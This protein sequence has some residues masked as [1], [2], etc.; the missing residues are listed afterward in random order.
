[1][2]CVASWRVW[3]LFL[4]RTPNFWNEKRI[5]IFRNIPDCAY[6]GRWGFYILGFEVGSRNHRDPLGMWLN[7][8]GL[9]RW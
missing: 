4:S 2:I 3:K 6:R 7:R 1:M 5:G 9:W 8:V